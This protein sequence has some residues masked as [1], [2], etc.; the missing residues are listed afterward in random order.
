M[1]FDD[2]I[3]EACDFVH[4]YTGIYVEN[5]IEKKSLKL[6]ISS[7]SKLSEDQHSQIAMSIL[8]HELGEMAYC[9][10]HE[11]EIQDYSGLKRLYG[12]IIGEY[13]IN[14]YE[15]KV[16]EKQLSK[17]KL[18]HKPPLLPLRYLIAN[19][20]I[21]KLEKLPEREQILS[22]QKIIFKQYPDDNRFH[23]LDKIASLLEKMKIM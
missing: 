3:K 5:Y 18:T 15:K 4:Y 9:I 2:A 7:D 22:I 11:D 16:V 19:H 10:A 14:L 21:E 1:N 23:I 8:V 20:Y 12:E 6:G 13:F 17:N